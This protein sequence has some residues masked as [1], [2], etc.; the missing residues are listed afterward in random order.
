MDVILKNGGNITQETD[1]GD[2]ALYLAV[3]HQQS[4]A[5]EYLADHGSDPSTTASFL[6]SVS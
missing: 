2:T 6:Y 1:T 5:V 3:H 4:A